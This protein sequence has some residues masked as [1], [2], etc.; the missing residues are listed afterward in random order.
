MKVHGCHKTLEIARDILEEKYSLL[1]KIKNI[2]EIRKLL[3][4][5]ILHM[6]MC[7]RGEFKKY[8]DFSNFKGG[9]M[10]HFTNKK[11]L[12]FLFKYQAEFLISPL[13]FSHF[14]LTFFNKKLQ[15]ELR[16]LVA[17]LR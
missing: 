4:R 3:C 13:V 8:G 12:T 11:L 17:D 7:I 10:E 14:V 5:Y 9:N 16:S 6:L 2:V 15:F 1:I